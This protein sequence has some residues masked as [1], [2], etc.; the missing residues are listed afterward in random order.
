M[1]YSKLD[2]AKAKQEKKS[3]QNPKLRTE[4]EAGPS[5]QREVKV[6]SSEDETYD[7]TEET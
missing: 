2:V 7:V 5:T 1:I 6:E 4:E 3:R